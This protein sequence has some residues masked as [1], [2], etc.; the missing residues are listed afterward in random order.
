M[1]IILNELVYQNATTRR[2]TVSRP[3]L[4][5]IIRF[6]AVAAANTVQVPEVCTQP[7][8]PPNLSENREA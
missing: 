8:K 3:P 4:H 7:L 1:L 2:V 5:S 6:S